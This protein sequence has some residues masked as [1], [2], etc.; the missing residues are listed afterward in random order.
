MAKNPPNINK[1]ATVGAVSG[2]GG[3]L[4]VWLTAIAASKWAVPIEVAAAV[5]SPV[6]GFLTGWMMK[7][8]AKLNPNG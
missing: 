8:A 6:F 4:V 2:T 7:W 5:V 1:A 3:A